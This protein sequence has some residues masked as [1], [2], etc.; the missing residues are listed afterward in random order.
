MSR[1]FNFAFISLLF[2]LIFS[3]CSETDPTPD[4]TVLGKPRMINGEEVTDGSVWQSPNPQGSYTPGDPDAE[5]GGS[6]YDDPNFNSF[7][8]GGSQNVLSSVY[9]D[10]DRSSIPP[11]ERPK[12]EAAAQFLKDNPGKSLIAEGHT[13]AIGTSEYNNAL[14]DRR[15]NSVKMYLEQLGIPGDRV[16][17]LAMGELNADQS[18][19]KGSPEAAQDRRVDLVEN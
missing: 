5:L 15:A 10:F 6:R 3:G 19:A 7:G 16:E 17:V 2:A 12:V 9:F 11:A 14:S 8:D 13:D 1:V 18:A 4:Q